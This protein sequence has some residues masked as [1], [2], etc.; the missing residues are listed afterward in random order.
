MI[1]S[2]FIIAWRNLWKNRLFSFIN[3]MGLGLAIPFALLSLIQVINVYEYDNFHPFPERTYRII[4]EVTDENGNKTKYAAS[5]FDLA[6]Q[7]KTDYPF[8]EQ[9]TKI[10][11]EMGWELSNRIKNIRVN[12]LFTEPSFHDIFGFYL[13]KGIWP[14]A[15]NSIVL[16]Q[17]KAEVFFGDA[18]P[19]GKILSHHDYGDLKVVGVLKPFKKKTH[20]KADVFVSMATYEKFNTHTSRMELPGYTYALLKKNNGRQNLATAL[21][22]IS[23]KRNT[24]IEAA[25]QSVHFHAQPLTDISPAYEELKGNLGAQSIWELSVN[26]AIALAIILL[27]GFNYTNLTLARSLSRAKE[28]GVRKVTGALRYQLISQ[29]ICEAILVALLSLGV[30][31]IVLKLMQQFVY[32][33]W[34]AWEVDNQ[35]ILWLAFIAFAVFI[36]VIAG[37][38]PARILSGFKPINVLKGTLAPASFGRISFRKSLVVIQ[39]VVTACFIFLIANLYSQF[40]Y[41]ATDNENFNR[42]NIY[43]LSVNGDFRLLKNEIASLK[44]VERIGLVSTPFGGTSASSG[45]KTSKQSQNSLASYYAANADFISNMNL[46]FVAGNNLPESN[47]DSATNFVVINEQAV[48]AL[49]F[50][51]PGEAIGKQIVLNDAKEVVIS[52]VVK[53]FCYFLYQFRVAP[54][55]MQYNPEQFHVLS[56]KTKTETPEGPL[57]ANIQ[58][59]WKK[60]NPYEELA[61]SNYE[62]DM[63]QRYYPGA[64]MKFMG[65]ICLVIFV[66]ALM[67]LIGMVTYTTEKRIKEIG[68]RKVMGASITTIVRELSGS[69][70]KLIAVAAVICIPLGYLSGYFFINL[71]A[72]NN[73]VNVWLMVSLFLLIFFIALITIALKTITAASVNPVKSLRTE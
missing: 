69:F 23:L 72:F 70:V 62:K 52:G 35:V 16:T 24:E 6:G 3:I 68:I 48:F 61:F 34:I 67:G 8:V 44:D 15:P 12:I 51:T 47:S 49:G 58:T 5:P 36:G 54:L 19:I 41:M 21:K 10:V 65:M 40:Q 55:V 39:F 13:Q 18:D 38:I 25:K 57:K 2:Y 59:I 46:Q 9:S 50:G 14:M 7:L 56:I 53:D 60:S 28:V 4:T 71:F 1:R 22:I 11:S 27:A 30:G 45:I 37:I 29:F 20:L 26:L 17:E 66:I 32:V 31:V 64:D 43:N 73:G 42:K 63:Y 33:N